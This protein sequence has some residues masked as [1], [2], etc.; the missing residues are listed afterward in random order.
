[1]DI[2]LNAHVHCTDGPCGH[3]TAVVMNPITEEVTHVVV[4]TKGMFHEAYMVP[5]DLI[6]DS[7]PHG[8]QLRC[9]LDELAKQEPFTKTRFIRLDGAG[10]EGEG[11][12]GVAFM[13][14]YATPDDMYLNS[15]PPY[16][17]VEQ[18]PHGELA[19][20]RG[21]QVEATDGPV[22]QVDE[23]LVNPEDCRITHLILRTGHLWGQKDVTIPLSQISRIDEDV[24]F[25]KLDR[26]AVGQLPSI[27]VRRK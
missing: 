13:W 27:P 25:L 18:V 3:T 8:L 24:V 19:I 1:M 12:G 22:G 11:P 5:L 20:H 4:Q 10:E 7:A 26:K 23:F 16:E 14:A 6:A 15:V 2:A 17:T 9:S 21:A